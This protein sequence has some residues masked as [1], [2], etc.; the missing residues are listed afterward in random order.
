MTGVRF[1]LK[2]TLLK[3]TPHTLR[4]TSQT[5]RRSPAPGS[6]LLFKAHRLLDLESDKEQEGRDV[7]FTLKLTLLKL[8]TDTLH[9]TANCSNSKAEALRTGIP[10]FGGFV[11]RAI[12]WVLI[13]KS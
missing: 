7:R 12:L 4:R 6:P 10:G 5:P 11:L 2:L 1:T 8:T 9:P 3:L 13:A